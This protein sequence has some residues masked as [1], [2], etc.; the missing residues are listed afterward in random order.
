M[1][2]TAFADHHD[3][4]VPAARVD[5]HHHLGSR[6]GSPRLDSYYSRKTQKKTPALS[7]LVKVLAK[8]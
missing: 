2:V 5:Y 8:M 7:F 3:P 4:P 1:T 6:S